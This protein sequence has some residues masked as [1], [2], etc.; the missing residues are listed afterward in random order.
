MK[1]ESIK[2]SLNNLRQRKTRSFFTIIS[3]LVGITTIFIFISYGLGLYAYVEEF[4]SEGT[5]DKVIIQPKSGTSMAG[6][7][8]TFKLT[9]DDLEAIKRA[10]GVYEVSG[11]YFKAAEVRKD[12]EV[13]YT[14]VF[15]YDPDKPLVMETFGLDIYQGRELMDGDTG[16]ALGYNYVFDDKIF[17]N[18]YS[19]G[20]KIEIQGEKFKILGFYEAVGSP[21][22]DAQ[23]YMT[24]ETMINLYSDEVL[25]YGWIV[26][27]VDI[28][29]VDGIVENI[30]KSL[31]KE[32]DLEEGKED[33]FVQSFGEMIEMYMNILNMIVGFVI[34]IA[35]ISVLVSAVNTAN[36]MITSVLE[37]KKE[38]GIMKSIGAKNS[39]I[40]NVFLFESS[41]LGFVAGCLGAG[42]GWVL[43]SIGGKILENVGYGFLQPAFP[44]VLFVGCIAFAT[45]TGAISGVVPALRAMKVNPVDALRYE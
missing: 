40:F 21:Q 12:K 18:G 5:A 27:R 17:S 15:G 39:E 10:S 3:I 35:L 19:L 8:T 45:L 30:E 38:I 43:S 44:P 33:Y 23:I 26:A 6:L 25:S 1:T 13:V 24:E 14:L 2:Y 20:E 7:D 28:S 22:D 16:V 31:R 34:L 42:L 4:T 36:T 29:N 32:R 41:F 11:S 9:D 37:R